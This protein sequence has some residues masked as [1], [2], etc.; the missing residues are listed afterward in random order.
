MVG[1]QTLRIEAPS[2]EP[3]LQRD[4]TMRL[5]RDQAGEP[6][7]AAR[8]EQNG[9][10]ISAQALSSGQSFVNHRGRWLLHD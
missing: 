9:N 10:C 4:S 6:G 3:A 7:A 1:R 5:V 2:D 8:Q